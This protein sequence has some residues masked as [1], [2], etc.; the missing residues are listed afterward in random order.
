MRLPFPWSKRAKPPAAGLEPVRALFTKFR[1]IQNLNTRALEKMSEME[2]ALGGEYIF[3]RAFLES[4]VRELGKIVYQVVYSLNTMSDNRYADLFDRFQTIRGSLED[5][6]GGGIGPYAG[7]LTLPYSLLSWDLEP[8]AGAMNVCMAEAGNS[9]GL[10]APDGFAVTAEGCRVLLES[11]GR[12]ETPGPQPGIP[13]PQSALEKSVRDEM[14]AL[15][16]RRGGPVPL[17][18]RACP[19]G[20]RREGGPQLEG[21]RGVNAG[22]VPAALSRALAEYLQN[23]GATP[24]NCAPVALAVHESVGALAAGT[25]S[26]IPRAGFPAGLFRIV[27]SPSDYPDR[28]E[29]YLVRRTYPYGPVQ[30]E[31]REKAPNAEIYPGITPLSSAKGLFR[32]SSLL[33]PDFLSAVAQCAATI[34][35]ILGWPF[36]LHWARGRA[37]RPII[38]GVSYLSMQENPATCELER[39]LEGTPVLL[40]GGETVQAG[41]AA[42]RTVRISDTTNVEQI[43]PGSVAIARTASPNLS[44]VLRR[45]SAMVTEVGSSIGHLATIARELR[46]PAV[47]G[48]RGV[49]ERVPEGLEVTV[50]AGERTIYG[51][52]VEHLLACRDYGTDLYPDDP[53]YI[54]LRRLLRWI[55]PLGLID[56]D[57][58]TFSV[59]NCRTYHDLIHFSHEKSVE[60]LLNIQDRGRGFGGLNA[61]RLG[62]DVPVDLFVL[63]LGG[64]LAAGAGDVIAPDEITSRPFRAFVQGLDVRAMWDRDPAPLRLK[65]IFSGLDRTFSAMGAPGAYS[66]RNHAIIAENYMNVGLRLGYHFSVIDCYLG[67]SVNQ[68]YIYFRFVGG[69]AEEKSRRRRAELIASILENLRFKTA[70]KGD[71]VTGKLKMEETGE[72]SAALAYLGQLTAF[73]RQLDLSMKSEEAVDRMLGDFTEKSAAEENRGKERTGG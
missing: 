51:G 34:E 49:L 9:L 62:L 53:E 13:D 20:P 32:G 12:C 61:R 33:G 15:F 45:V 60:Q 10:L 46:V 44:S 4:S 47:F 70:V 16:G 3:D 37:N 58:S 35:R 5:I 2:R 6:L 29:Q 66:G 11:L 40:K 68:N 71:L 1:R 72:I 52:I 42:G 28:V 19:A 63:D 38:T 43:P 23:T 22:D 50:D 65:D 54:E 48:A 39:S 18:V 17:T 21:A 55:M 24:Q 26:S 69:L 25:V 67:E 30:S 56:P 27:A 73:T 8:V 7:S 36:E 57:S 59:E 31:I 64:G 14:E 41:I